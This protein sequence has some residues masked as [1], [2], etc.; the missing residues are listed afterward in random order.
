[1]LKRDEVSHKLSVEKEPKLGECSLKTSNPFSVLD[2]KRY[3]SYVNSSLLQEAATKGV[4]INKQKLDK[5]IKNFNLFF[6]IIKF[7]PLYVLFFEYLTYN[8]LIII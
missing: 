2:F 3:L 6:N 5:G 8:N 4:D 7:N 1:M